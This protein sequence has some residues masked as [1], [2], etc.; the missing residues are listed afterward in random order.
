MPQNDV[1]QEKSCHKVYKFWS[2]TTND[3]CVGRDFF[4][5]IRIIDWQQKI[6]TGVLAAI[7]DT[8]ADIHLI[9]ESFLSFNISNWR[10]RLKHFEPELKIKG[11]SG[12]TLNID[13]VVVLPV[14]FPAIKRTF[15][16]KFYVTKSGP[17]HL[18]FA[19]SILITLQADLY[20][21]ELTPRTDNPHP[22]DKHTLVL[23][24]KLFKARIFC[25]HFDGELSHYA[26]TKRIILEERK[27]T[28]IKL[29]LPYN[30]GLTKHSYCAVF[31]TENSFETLLA[32][33]HLDSELLHF[34]PTGCSPELVNNKLRTTTRWGKM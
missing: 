11:I 18:L 4:L 27:L 20:F 9:S 10:S 3:S 1:I 6:K 19:K 32:Q 23:F 2:E 25:L 12:T 15:N 29:F 8:G 30:P 26:Y 7:L 5:P 13:C 24:S 17:P 21:T 22:C 33:Q 16:L 14:K 34:T 31:P 28:P